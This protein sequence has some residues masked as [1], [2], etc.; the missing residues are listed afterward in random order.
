MGKDGIIREGEEEGVRKGFKGMEERSEV[1]VTKITQGKLEL[2]FRLK[3]DNKLEIVKYPR[4]K[5]LQNS[6]K[7][8]YISG[9]L[10]HFSCV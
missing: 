6:Q 4:M 3:G 7:M 5:F 8:E 1:K 9:S 10:F 2:T